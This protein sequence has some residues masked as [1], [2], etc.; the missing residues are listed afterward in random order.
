MP[1]IEGAGQQANCC[2][3]KVVYFG[4]LV[5]VATRAASIA[6]DGKALADMR[7]NRSSRRDAVVDL[8]ALIPQS[9]NLFVRLAQWIR[10]Q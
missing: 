10:S 9:S 5:T 7:Q 1:M 2:R 3:R 6:P 8:S 4:Q